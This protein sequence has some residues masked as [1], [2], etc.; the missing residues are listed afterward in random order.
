[1]PGDYR[2]VSLTSAIAKLIEKVV[3]RRLLS[4]WKPSQYQYA[5]RAHFSTETALMQVADWV[6]DC[7]N[8]HHASTNNKGE[9]VWNRDRALA[10]F[11]DFSAAFDL[12][13]HRL[14]SK[15]LR[16]KIKSSLLINWFDRF[17]YNRKDLTFMVHCDTLEDGQLQAAEVLK[18]IDRWSAENKMKINAAKSEALL[19]TLSSR[20]SAEKVPDASIPLGQDS[21]KVHAAHKDSLCKLL[22]LSFK[23]RASFSNHLRRISSTVRAR[24][25][26]LSSVCTVTS[27][28]PPHMASTFYKGFVESPALY[29][30]SVDTA[31]AT[32]TSFDRLETSEGKGPFIFYRGL[33]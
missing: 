19:F 28:P 32:K 4:L 5:H 11:I 9:F 22:G 13:D 15:K 30:S 17:L 20:T 33:R 3:V 26:Q 21:I 27:G 7:L 8:S 2:P 10:V 23:N 6:H 12:I 1:M 31:K 29:G 18:V 25:A 14:L 16:A 24:A